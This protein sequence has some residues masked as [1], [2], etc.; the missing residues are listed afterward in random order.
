MRAFDACRDYRNSDTLVSFIGLRRERRSEC[1]FPVWHSWPCPAVS[2]HGIK[3]RTPT[4]RDP[5][6]RLENGRPLYV[7]FRPAYH[8]NRTTTSNGQSIQSRPQ[9]K[10]IRRA[11]DSLAVPRKATRDRKAVSGAAGNLA[12]RPNGKSIFNIVHKYP[13]NING[14]DHCVQ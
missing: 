12:G 4:R 13:G 1:H 8:L 2:R 7:S 11:G 9:R 3:P 10:P 14:R 5:D 6:L